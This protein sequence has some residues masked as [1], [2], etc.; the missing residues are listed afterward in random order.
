MVFSPVYP[1]ELVTMVALPGA[2]KKKQSSSEN[3]RRRLIVMWLCRVR[4]VHGGQTRF[5]DVC[6]LSGGYR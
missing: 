4:N 5:K 3:Y 6:V 1:D 2:K